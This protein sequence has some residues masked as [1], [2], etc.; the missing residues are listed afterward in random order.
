MRI[1]KGIKGIC[2][3]LVFLLCGGLGLAARSPTTK[4]PSITG[5]IKVKGEHKKRRK[6]RMDADPKCAA[7]YAEPPLTNDLVVDENGNV[8]WAFVYVETG[9]EGRSSADPLPAAVIDQKGCRYHPHVLGVVVGQDL[10]IRNDDD[11]L[12]NIHGLPFANR[13]FNFGQP[14]KGLEAHERFANQEIMVKV[15][16]DVH[17]WMSA[18]IGVVDHPFFAVTDAAGN[19]AI[20]GGLPDGKYTLEVWHEH[21]KSISADVEVRGGT[22]VAD[23]VLAERKE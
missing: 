8:E 19:Y 3:A 13:E 5:N 17:P 6:L 15:K 4:V 2:V 21:Y 16:C 11:L 9:A 7:M 10:T 23:F 12:H 22:A 18:W 1:L 20:P 14:M